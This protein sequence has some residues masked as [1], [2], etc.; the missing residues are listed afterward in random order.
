MGV[1]IVDL[2]RPLEV[3]IV[4]KLA[5][6]TGCVFLLAAV[7]QAAGQS[8]VPSTLPVQ[9]NAT[10]T[11]HSD[12]RLV[13]IDVVVKHHHEPVKGLTA[14]DF[15]LLEDGKPQ[16]IAF[17]D[18]HSAP[19]SSERSVNETREAD[20]FT[21]D[22]AEP[23][24]SV[25]VILFDTLNTPAGDQPYARKQMIGFLK[26]LPSGYHVALFE[27]G[28]KLRMLA[29]FSENSEELVA[30]ADKLV[31][32]VS[33]LLQTDEDLLQE[34]KEIAK[35]RMPYNGE[36]VEAMQQFMS[37]T[38]AAVAQNRVRL[39]LQDLNTLAGAMSGFRGRKNVI[40]LSEYFPV[41]FGFMGDSNEFPEVQRY[42]DLMSGTSSKLSSSQVALYPIDIRGL[43][44]GFFGNA[45]LEGKAVDNLSAIQ[46][47][48]ARHLGMDEIAEDTGGHA[49]YNTNDLKFAMQRSFESGSEYYTL[50][51]V[52]P[53]GSD[54]KYHR[55]NVRFTRP[56]LTGE[57]RKGYFALP[58]KPSNDSGSEFAA[59]VR[60][61]T[62]VLNRLHL[63]ARLQPPNLK[64]PD[65]VVECTISTEDLTFVE[66]P[67]N[68]KLVTLNLLT[69]AWDKYLNM[70]GRV[71]NTVELQFSPEQYAR[72]LRDG[73]TTRQ[74]MHLSNPG[75]YD[76]R[77]A[78]MDDGNRRIGSLEI[79]IEISS[80]AK[81]AKK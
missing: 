6:L 62:P 55:I 80:D 63:K 76:I 54:S 70:V 35:T 64:H 21:N 18:A 36:S 81:L 61:A 27:L 44:S 3:L 66:Q 33:P 16:K 69:V 23:P 12:S 38:S 50:A 26:T 74:Q 56:G 45:A 19:R 29:G 42:R 25:N 67:N 77:T 1:S 51:Y 15:I 40:W 37:A 68:R 65:T 11:L 34:Q 32:H 10:T 58:I 41:F 39:T 2:S 78:V 20:V 13:L 75:R 8:P 47:I 17:F 43:T 14:S 31:P 52:P 79:P 22:T 71:S 49:Y 9:Q 4:Q 30:A 73:I 53:N 46:G 48:E 60:P 24:P 57:H 28:A 5:S 59:A 7:A 72:V